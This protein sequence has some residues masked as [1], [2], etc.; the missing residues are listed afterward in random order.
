MQTIRH[1]TTPTIKQQTLTIKQQTHTMKTG[2]T[3]SLITT[4]IIINLHHH[5]DAA[6]VQYGVAATTMIL[7]GTTHIL[8]CHLIF[9]HS[10]IF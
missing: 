7:I 8:D 1:G 10:F 4:Q 3:Q 6:K 5:T 9:I 2:T